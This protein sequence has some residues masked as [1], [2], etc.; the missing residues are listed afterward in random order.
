[1]DVAEED[2]IGPSCGFLAV[3]KGQCYDVF[4]VGGPLEGLDRRVEVALV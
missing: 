1:M 4:E 3:I 2:A